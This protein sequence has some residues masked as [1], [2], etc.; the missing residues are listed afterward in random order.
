MSLMGYGFGVAEVSYVIVFGLLI[1][2]GIAPSPLDKVEFSPI[3][4]VVYG[5]YERFLATMFHTFSIDMITWGQLT[6]CSI[7]QNLLLHSSLISSGVI[8]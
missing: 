8:L 1:D 6:I 3:K 4:G 5:G 7:F 2:L